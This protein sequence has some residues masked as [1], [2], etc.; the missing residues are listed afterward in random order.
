M[1]GGAPQLGTPGRR[2]RTLPALVCGA[3]SGPGGV[4]GA[5]WCSRRG[6]RRQRAVSRAEK[7]ELHPDAGSGRR[8]RASSVLVLTCGRP[9]CVCEHRGGVCDR[10]RWRLRPPE[11]GCDRVDAAGCGRRRLGYI[12]CLIYCFPGRWH[13]WLLR[14]S[15]P[16]ELLATLARPTRHRGCCEPRLRRP[17]TA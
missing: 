2:R 8:L 9:R 17:K 4:P 10:S 14:P 3:R 15:G 16:R 13:L 11:C 12:Y 1:G 5:E 7:W 6:W